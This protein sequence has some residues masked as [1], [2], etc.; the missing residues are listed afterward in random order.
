MVRSIVALL[1]TI[2]ISAHSYG[3]NRV[4]LDLPDFKN[5]EPEWSPDGNFIVF[6]SKRDGVSEIYL[7][8]S[9]GTNQKRL[10][11]KGGTAAHW[12]PDGKKILFHSKRTGVEQIFVMNADGSDQINLTGT[13]SL[14]VNGVWSPSG[15]K[16]AFMSTRDG[17]SN[18]Y[19]MDPYGSYQR[20]IVEAKNNLSLPTWS[21]DGNCIVSRIVEVPLFNYVRTNLVDGTDVILFENSN[22][23]INFFGWIDKMNKIVYSKGENMPS[24]QSVS[25]IYLTDA[26]GKNEKPIAKRILNLTSGRISPDE[27]KLIYES[28]NVVYVLDITTG[29]SLKVGRNHFSAEWSHDG[30]FIVMVAEKNLKMN[31]CTV[32]ADG[33]NLKQLTF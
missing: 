32:N 29:K 6:T 1:F 24:F 26:N 5:T 8:N 20:P 18:V 19:I 33:T 9:D 10:T 7:M 17:K 4:K 30:K 12:S 25:T 27:T 28:N 16:I 22:N 23:H 14:E 21:P 15:D 2:S 11:T 13:K 31:I 3:Q